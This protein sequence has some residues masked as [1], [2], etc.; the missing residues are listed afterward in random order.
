MALDADLLRTSFETV[1]ERQPLITPRFYEILFSRHPSV[2]PLFGR[3]S[4]RAQE[5]MLQQALVAVIDH[6]E[7]ASWLSSNLAALGAKHIDYGVTPEMFGAVGEA[8]LATL[9]EI[10][11]DDWTPKVCA[12]W[13]AAYAA[14][15]ELML[16][17]MTPRSAIP[18]PTDSSASLG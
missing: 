13:E 17:R 3:N 18:R 7:D 4:S 11:G 15:C 12:A 5:Q 8:L 16:A 14:I 1:I 9:A 2:K 6:L 10:L